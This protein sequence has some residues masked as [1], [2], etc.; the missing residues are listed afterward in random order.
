MRYRV[1]FEKRLQSDGHESPIDPTALL[2]EE[3][4]DGVVAEKVFV[5]RLEPD[6]QHSQE[7]LD[8]DDAFLA[9]AGTGSLGVRSNKRS[10]PRIRRRHTQFESRFRIHGGG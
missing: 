2:D 8:E 9:L 3:L 6:A 7:T 1:A 4:A 5:E 10:P